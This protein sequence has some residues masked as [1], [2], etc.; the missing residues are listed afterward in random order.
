MDKIF[1]GFLLLLSFFSIVPLSAELGCALEL[2]SAAFFHKDRLF[3]EIY[4]DVNACYEVEATVALN[5]C[6]ETWANFDWFSRRGKSIG[7]GDPTR[8]RIANLSFGIKFPY[9]INNCLLFYAGIGPSFSRI[10]IWNE[11]IFLREHV[12]RIAYG[13][14]VKLGIDY[15]IT[16]N[17]FIDLFV[18]YLYQPVKFQ[19]RLDIGGFK[20]GLGIGYRF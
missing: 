7:L 6:L 5:S 15:F 17:L 8:V 13:G 14:I 19:N 3:R 16:D 10:C 2:R 11:S 1:V 9:Q 18:D 20:P 12:S 4:G